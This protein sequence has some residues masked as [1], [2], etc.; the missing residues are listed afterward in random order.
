MRTPIAGRLAVFDAEA[1]TPTWGTGKTLAEHTAHNAAEFAT[2]TQALLIA[3]VLGMV[4]AKAIDGDAMRAYLASL[5][6]DLS[7]AERSQ[8]YGYCLSSMLA[9]LGSTPLDTPTT[10]AN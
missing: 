7:P 2:A 8:A 5:Y 6:A 9:A 4:S 1:F 10:A 3:V